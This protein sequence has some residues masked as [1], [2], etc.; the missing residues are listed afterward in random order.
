MRWNSTTLIK[1]IVKELP[2]FVL[3]ASALA[4]GA[5][6]DLLH[7]CDIEDLT[8][9]YVFGLTCRFLGGIAMALTLAYCAT[10]IIVAARRRWVKYAF[11]IIATIA[12]AT[13]LFIWFNFGTRLSPEILNI[14]FE[15]DLSET[16]EFWATFGTSTGTISALAATLGYITICHIAEAWWA[17][18]QHHISAS[19]C[20]NRLAS[21][22]LIACIGYAMLFWWIAMPFLH[23]G[24]Q[25]S[26]LNFGSDAFT[27]TMMA[28]YGVKHVGDNTQDAINVTR[29]ATRFKPVCTNNDSLSVV[30]VIGESYI[31]HHAQVYGYP[32]NTTPRLAQEK[33]SGNLFVFNDFVSPYTFTSLTLR[34]LFSTN[35]MAMGE[36]WYEMP[37][38]TAIFKQAGFYVTMW[39]NQRQYMQHTPFQANLNSF[40]YDKEVIGLCYNH[41]NAKCFEYDAPLIQDFK[42][43]CTS[44]H[45]HNLAIFHLKG[46][47]FDARQRVPNAKRFQVF[48]VKDYIADKWNYLTD[49]KRQVIADY[50]NAT[51]YN[52]YVIGLIID[53]FSNTNAVMIYLADH[54]EEVFD[55]RDSR[56]RK[57]PQGDVKNYVKYQNEV[58]FI[59]W[60]SDKFKDNYPELVNS[61]RLAID[62][63]AMID[64]VGHSLLHI[65]SISTP[66]YTPE[67]DILNDNFTPHQRIVDENINYDELMNSKQ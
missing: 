29:K 54:G 17:K 1:P 21:C 26:A 5:I 60:C 47:H 23:G 37:L 15:T 24:K 44:Q 4:I 7:I 30:L 51:L 13:F 63:P 61:I 66:F 42:T 40:I 52:D 64:I 67:N 39:D 14:I 50:D 32:L 22:A 34:N 38:F 8:P 31:K 41:M 55:Y 46:Q 25:H 20:R 18:R 35:R 56:G 49:K 10:C 2:F 12:L 19:K 16:A 53:L 58:P 48:S 59:V 28:A 45:K 62:R 9:R 43:S 11:Y 36:Q 27:N 6:V 33:N 3:F 65:A 57:K